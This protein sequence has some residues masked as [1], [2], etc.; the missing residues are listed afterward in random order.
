MHELTSVAVYCGS[1][2]KVSPRYLDSARAFGGLLARRGTRLVF[3]AGSVGMMGAVADGALAG[4]G[5]AV[6]VIPHKLVELELAH[7]GL[8]R[9]EIVDD[10]HQRKA[11][12]TNLS[13]AF[14][15]M[16]G[17]YGTLDELFEA[18]TWAQ[19]NYHHKPIGL[20]NVDG[21]F[22]HLVAFLDHA[23]GE[24]FIRPVHRELL[25]VDAH[26]DVL[27]DALAATRVPLLDEWIEDV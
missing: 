24:G 26:P 19:L 21:Y 12:M 25:Q 2:T 15:A 17:G 5:E 4:G 20:L 13:D 22:D 11:L 14:V 8:T 1:S 10:M 6:G 9:T 7:P 23:T 3:G 27:L 16:P 18:I